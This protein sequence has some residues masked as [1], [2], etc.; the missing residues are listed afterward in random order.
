MNSSLK[1]KINHRLK[2]YV[3]CRIK[4]YKLNDINKFLSKAI[5]EFILR[6]GKRIRPILFL[7]A[8]SGYGGKRLNKQI[9]ETSLAFELLHDFL[10]IH[11]DIIDNS[12]TR[13][14]KPTIHKIFAANLKKNE[15][16]GKSIAIVSADII[17]SLAIEAFLSINT[18]QKNKETALK[19][20]LQ[21]VTLTGAG[22]IKDVLNSLIKIKE[23]SLEEIRLNYQLKT[24][25]YTFK[26]PLACGCILAGANKKQAELMS[27]YGGFL[28]EAF[29]IYDD[30]IGL[31]GNSKKIGKSV[32][33][34]LIEAKKTLPIFLTYQKANISERKFINFCLGNKNLNFSD[35]QKIRKIIIKTEALAQTNNT[36]KQLMLQA[37]NLLKSS[38]MSEKYK[39][40]ISSYANSYIKGLQN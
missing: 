20:F 5:E 11:D 4:I 25:E 15:E 32:L 18:T 28:G 16:M 2:E 27:D 17:F 8:Y 40:I 12:A 33:S 1:T 6:N 26:S 19:I 38:K 3:T 34:D 10:L 22:E 29:Q 36:I 9:I 24:A 14:G 13:R 7:L 30:L 37:D 23:I 31:F 35:L 21:S 39:K